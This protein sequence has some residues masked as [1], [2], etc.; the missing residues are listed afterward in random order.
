MVETFL[1]FT[2]KLAPHFDFLENVG[3]IEKIKVI[4]YFLSKALDKAEKLNTEP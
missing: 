4:K 3:N 2:E 1:N